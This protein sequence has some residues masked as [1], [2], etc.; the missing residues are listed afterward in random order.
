MAAT[1]PLTKCTF[2]YQSHPSYN[3]PKHQ[4]NPVDVPQKWEML[5][6]PGMR[7]CLTGNMHS[8]RGPTYRPFWIR[9]EV[10]CRIFMRSRMVVSGVSQACLQLACRAAIGGCASCDGVFNMFRGLLQEIADCRIN[11]VS[12]A[13]RILEV[14]SPFCV[15]L[16]LHTYQ[17]L[18]NP[19]Y[20]PT[21]YLLSGL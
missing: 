14:N 19:L 18:G 9:A 13:W 20:H 10:R 17:I 8:T 21:L 7:I 16:L 4:L 3:H 2:M 15:C 11:R 6:Q 1:K 5:Q 12:W